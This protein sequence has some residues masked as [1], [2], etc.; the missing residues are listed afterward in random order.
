MTNETHEVS[1]DRLAGFTEPSRSKSSRELHESFIAS[2]EILPGG[3]RH[4]V[5]APQRMRQGFRRVREEFPS[6]GEG[7][8]LRRVPQNSHGTVQPEEIGDLRGLRIPY[9]FSLLLA[10]FRGGGSG[11]GLKEIRL[12]QLCMPYFVEIIERHGAARADFW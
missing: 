7:V 9:C 10:V 5:K 1:G 12:I 3:A 11:R 6:Q 4:A 2:L 8:D